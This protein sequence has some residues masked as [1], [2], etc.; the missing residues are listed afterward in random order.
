MKKLGLIG[1]TLTTI[2]SSASAQTSCNENSC[3]GHAEKLVPSILVSQQET[4]LRIASDES[5]QLTCSLKSGDYAVLNDKSKSGTVQ[6]NLLTMAVAG[7][8]DVVITF[9]DTDRECTVSSV[10]LITP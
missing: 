4:L 1:L 5:S 9:A 2:L 7:Q 3:Q 6:R 10:E 8:F